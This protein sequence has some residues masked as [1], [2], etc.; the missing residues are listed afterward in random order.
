[1]REL[2]R[3]ISD[4]ARGWA[5]ADCLTSF[6]NS[7]VTA[8]GDY[9]CVVRNAPG[10]VTS[11]VATVTVTR[12]PLRFVPA[13]SQL[14]SAGFQMRLS[15][16]AGSG[17]AIVYASTNLVDWE[18]ITTNPPFAGDMDFL[19]PDATNRPARLYRAVETSQ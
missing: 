2:P 10:S 18:A 5:F 3:D 11:E 9:R 16:L 7:P 8:A 4:L 19:D 15:G 17:P 12:P 13:S 1:L 14:T 6:I